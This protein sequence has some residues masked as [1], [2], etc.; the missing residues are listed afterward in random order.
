MTTRAELR[1]VQGTSTEGDG[2]SAITNGVVSAGRGVI[3]IE[4]MT[5]SESR[6]RIYSRSHETQT[7]SPDYEGIW[8]R[9]LRNAPDLAVLAVKRT[10][11]RA[12]FTA[13]RRCFG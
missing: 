3:E 11:T 7:N 9:V 13:A 5:V 6:W 2:G 1:F 12:S 8:Q 4:W 10:G